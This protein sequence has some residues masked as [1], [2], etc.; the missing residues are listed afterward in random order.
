MKREERL[1]QKMVDEHVTTEPRDAPV[2]SE[3]VLH[4]YIA[5]AVGGLY[6]T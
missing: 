5:G 3:H 6:I 1:I 4:D 2:I